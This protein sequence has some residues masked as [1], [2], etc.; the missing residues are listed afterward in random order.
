G[1][2]TQISVIGNE[3]MVGISAVMG[4]CV[5]PTSV[6]SLS[7]GHVLRLD[8]EIFK[9]TFE[10]SESFRR[11]L[12]RY[13]AAVMADIGQTTVCARYHSLEQQLCRWLLAGLDRLQS[14][15]IVATHE[16]IAAILGVRRETVTSI[17]GKLEQD[18]LIQYSRGHISIVDPCALKSRA[19][20]CY[21][22]IKNQYD[23]ILP[24][25]DDRIHVIEA[26]CRLPNS[27]NTTDAFA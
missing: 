13:L 26:G 7:D 4:E 12:L 15:E 9:R 1:K 16:V 3:G 27:I 6:I 14:S 19:C 21:E 5:I 10:H 23:V 11:I 25:P 24:V 20:E 18:G 2:S 17:A 22:V 8:K